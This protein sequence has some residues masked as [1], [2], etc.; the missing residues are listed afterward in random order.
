M[1]ISHKKLLVF[2]IVAITITGLSFVA[3]LTIGINSKFYV[4][5]SDSMVPNLYTGDVVVVDRDES[6]IRSSF[7]TL[8][9]GDIIVFRPGSQTI[10]DQGPGKIIVHRVVEV[11]TD[12]NGS[13]VIRTKGDANSYS[14]QALDYPITE[15]NYVGKV[16]HIIRYLGVLLMYL[17]ILIRVF[18]HPLLYIIIGAIIAIICVLELRKRRV[19]IRNLN[20]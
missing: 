20:E 10:Q 19:F 5:F 1:I 12:S 18:L 7:S 16:I 6:N 9:I 15:E 17:D 11:E 2:I 4:V 14:I 13:R 3:I 8:K